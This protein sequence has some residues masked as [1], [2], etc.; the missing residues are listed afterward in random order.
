MPWKW[1]IIVQIQEKVPTNCHTQ[2]LQNDLLYGTL[3]LSA[4]QEER[5][6]RYNERMH[7][8]ARKWGSAFGIAFVA[9]ASLRA[10]AKVWESSARQL[11]KRLAP[12]KDAKAPMPWTRKSLDLSPGR[13]CKLAGIDLSC[14]VDPLLA[15]TSTLSRALSVRPRAGPTSCSVGLSLP[16]LSRRRGKS[17]ILIYM[18]VFPEIRCG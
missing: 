4:R 1:E 7:L 18:Y 17:A 16:P 8:L 5:K 14:M 3:V 9:R 6:S 13:Q 10:L 11:E 15:A 2:F 12:E